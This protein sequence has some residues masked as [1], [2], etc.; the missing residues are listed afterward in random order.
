MTFP[1]DRSRE[2]EI[3]FGAWRWQ[4]QALFLSGLSAALLMGLVWIVPPGLGLPLF[5]TVLLVS[6]GLVAAYAWWSGARMGGNRVSAWDVAGSC[7]LVGFA[8]AIMSRPEQV[9]QLVAS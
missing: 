2:P 9:L 7:V 1:V 4:V 8:A 3:G 5:A 6:G